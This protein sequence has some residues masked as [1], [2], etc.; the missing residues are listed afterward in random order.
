M[1]GNNPV[2][3]VFY[4]ILIALAL[5]VIIYG[6]YVLIQVI[7]R[8]DVTFV[9][10][11]IIFGCGFFSNITIIIFYAVDPF[12]SRQILTYPVINFLFINSVPLT[13]INAIIIAMIWMV[14]LKKDL[15]ITLKEWTRTLLIVVTIISLITYPSMMITVLFVGDTNI[16]AYALTIFFF[17]A[18][19][20]FI[21]IYYFIY[22]IR[23]II[24]IRKLK[25]MDY[26]KL[27]L[28]KILVILFFFFSYWLE[29]PVFQILVR[30]I[31]IWSEYLY[32][33][34]GL[35]RL[36]FYSFIS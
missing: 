23:I 3:V 5:A 2:T 20:V 11:I 19:V 25:T 29:L 13:V 17:L 16:Y 34:L 14:V 15:N 36:I 9:L 24:Q 12:F 8:R 18:V 22:V 28:D 33:T 21:I 6:I 35:L 7:K 31:Y 27:N 30:Y 26:N 32:N 4:F 10:Q 1:V